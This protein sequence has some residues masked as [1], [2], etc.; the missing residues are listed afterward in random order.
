MLA[1]GHKEEFIYSEDIVTVWPMLSDIVSDPQGF[2]GR[3]ISIIGSLFR[4][5][6]TRERIADWVETLE[7]ERGL[8]EEPAP[9]TSLTTTSTSKQRSFKHG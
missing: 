9:T 8:I 3:M 4:D 1:I 2:S 5:R 6:W 7:L